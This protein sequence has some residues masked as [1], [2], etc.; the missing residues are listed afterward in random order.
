MLH[1]DVFSPSLEPRVCGSS[2]NMKTQKQLQSINF[3]KLKATGYVS[4]ESEGYRHGDSFGVFFQFI[5]SGDDDP[6]SDDQKDFFQNFEWNLREM[7]NIMGGTV[8]DSAGVETFKDLRINR[9]LTERQFLELKGLFEKQRKGPPMKASGLPNN[10]ADGVDYDA[11][12]EPVV[13]RLLND[14]KGL[15]FQFSSICTHKQ[16]FVSIFV[17]SCPPPCAASDILGGINL[18]KRMC[19]GTMVIEPPYTVNGPVAVFLQ[20]MPVVARAADDPLDIEEKTFFQN[21]SKIW[22]R[23]PGRLVQKLEPLPKSISVTI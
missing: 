20:F 23:W 17:C 6:L 15:Y 10:P 21:L 8:R 14:S 3:E 16:T 7:A 9:Y 2:I 19:I 13:E 22:L 12:Q 11:Q 4:S 1:K 18:D 5:P